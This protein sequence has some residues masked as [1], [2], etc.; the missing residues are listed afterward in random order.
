MGIR[1]ETSEGMQMKNQKTT[2]QKVSKRKVTAQPLK[3]KV[4]IVTGA[5]RGLGKYY[6][7]ALAEAGAKVA[8]ASRSDQPARL[9]GTIHETVEEIR[10]AGGEA[11]AVKCD[12]SVP[13]DIQF[14]MGETVYRFGRVDVLVNNAAN[15]QRMPFFNV[16]PDWWDNYF[17]TNLRAAYFATQ[18]AAPHMMRQGGGSIINI[19]S[20]AGTASVYDPMLEHHG[21]YMISKGALNRLT[22]CLSEELKP[23]NIAVNAINPGAVSTDGLADRV[24]QRLRG[25]SGLDFREPSVALVKNGI[26]TLALQDAGGVTG[27]ILHADEFNKFNNAESAAPRKRSV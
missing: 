20:G 9:P 7:L 21:L 24:P 27:R 1:R 16:T 3:G 14:L 25:R 19:T 26:V 8:V 5:S 17:N 18:A 2:K 11:I 12:V 23:C 15:A 6:A 22:V 13:N 4:A 10:R